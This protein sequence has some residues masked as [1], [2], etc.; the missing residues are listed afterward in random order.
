MEGGS[1]YV[2]DWNSY[3]TRIF[4]V[5]IYSYDYPTSKYNFFVL[6]LWNSTKKIIDREYHHYHFESN[7]IW[8][9][10][11]IEGSDIQYLNCISLSY[12]FQITIRAIPEIYGCKGRKA[13]QTLNLISNKI[14][15]L[16]MTVYSYY[17][18]YRVKSLFVHKY[19][20]LY[21]I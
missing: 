13:H 4:R 18:Q 8:I 15:M 5:L 7:K 20:R 3:F 21:F 19:F 2:Q 1:S 10:T 12:L 17:L 14:L 6:W 11:E 9:H 16:I